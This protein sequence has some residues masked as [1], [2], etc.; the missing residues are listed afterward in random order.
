M[1]MDEKKSSTRNSFGRKLE[2]LLITTGVKNAT[3]A[4]ALSYDVSYISKWITGKSIPSGKNVEK[5]LAVISRIIVDETTDEVKESLMSEFGVR[6]EA[7]LYEAIAGFLLEGYYEVTGGG[8][9]QH[10]INNASF[11]VAPKRQFPL[12][13][14]YA[15]AQDKTKPMDIAVLVDLFSL[16]H[17]SKLGMAGIQDQTFGLKE[18]REDIRI[19]YVVDISALDGNNVYDVILLIHMMTCFSMAKF[20]LYY[21]ELARG[22]VLISVKNEYAGVS[23]LGE[24]QQ[25]LCTTA[26][27]DKR[28]VGELYESIAASID[29]DRTIFLGTDMG[30]LLRS[31]EYLQTLLSRDVRWLVGHM[32]E[33]FLSPELFQTLSRTHLD[34]EERVEAERAFRLTGNM[35]KKGQIRVMMYLTAM[36]DFVLSGELDFFNRRVILTPDQRKEQLVYLLELLKTTDCAGFKLIRD[37]FSED[38]KY[39][40]NPCMFLSGSMDYLRLEN[41][42]YRD[43]LLVM[44]DESVK[45]IFDVF[46]ERIWGYDTAVVMSAP[47]DILGSLEDLIEKSDLLTNM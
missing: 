2:Q 47:R 8:P 20:R 3:I 22:K 10:H 38:F 27:K 15:Q 28:L 19:D 37:G 36:M 31:H 29:P 1:T 42:L 6:S 16:D 24:N 46:F 34:E 7:A 13:Q 23:L 11:T 44:K 5:N 26:T 33:H 45:R 30:D 12:L 21:S 25:F 43:N 14:E 4:A 17:V 18:K 32:T 40:T 35:L 9:E 39:I 41:K